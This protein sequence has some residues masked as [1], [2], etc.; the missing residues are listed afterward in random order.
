ILWAVYA[1][2]LVF[3]GIRRRYRPI[4][5]LA[6][7]LFGFT[8]L[9]VFMVDI[10]RLDRVSKMLSVMGLGILLL[11]ASYL[12]QRVRADA[13]RPTAPPPGAPPPAATTAGASA[14][15]P[16]GSAAARI[17][18]TDRM[19]GDSW[20]QA[21]ILIVDDESHVARLLER[22]LRTDAYTAI[23]STTDPREAVALFE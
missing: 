17:G 10:A 22:L 6:I 11:I 3:A 12:Y 14:S 16:P 18:A 21:T 5:Y 4:R 1:V 2:G 9:K 8:I 13:G 23:Q 7:L 19:S 15:P 20:K